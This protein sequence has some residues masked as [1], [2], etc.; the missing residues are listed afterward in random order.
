MINGFVDYGIKHFRKQLCLPSHHNCLGSSCSSPCYISPEQ[1]LQSQGNSLSGWQFPGHFPHLPGVPGGTLLLSAELSG[2][3]CLQYCF[4][5]VIFV[6][7]SKE[8]ENIQSLFK[9]YCLS[10][11]SGSNLKGETKIPVCI[12]NFLLHYVHSG[13][14][15]KT[16]KFLK[17]R[18]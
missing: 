6:F 13:L 8:R 7:L 16:N 3:R 17:A 18:N 9:C 5:I 1:E 10:T 11:R 4:R 12:C 15:F 14:P 2:S